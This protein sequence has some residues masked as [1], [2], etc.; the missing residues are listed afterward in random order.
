M[1]KQPSNK[2]R[3]NITFSVPISILS[4]IGLHFVIKSKCD[5]DWLVHKLELPKNKT[6]SITIMRGLLV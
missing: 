4:K 3:N 1:K 6:I 2:K 5:S